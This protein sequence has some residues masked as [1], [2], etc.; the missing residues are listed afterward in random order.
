M[1][2]SLVIANCSTVR[3]AAR[4]LDVGH[5]R[6]VVVDRADAFSHA[7]VRPAGERTLA[8]APL[9]PHVAADALGVV[10]Q[11]QDFVADEQDGNRVDLGR[12]GDVQ[13]ERAYCGVEVGRAVR[14]RVGERLIGDLRGQRDRVGLED[15][16]V[17]REVVQ[18]AHVGGAEDV[19]VD[20]L[21]DL[22]REVVVDIGQVVDGPGVVPVGDRQVV[23]GPQLVQ[24]AGAGLEDE[25]LVDLADLRV[26]RFVR[27]ERL[28]DLQAVG[29]VE[30]AGLLAPGGGVDVGERHVPDGVQP[31]AVGG[32]LTDH[33]VVRGSVSQRVDGD[34]SGIERNVSEAQR[35]AQRAGQ[36]VAGVRPDHF[37]VAHHAVPGDVGGGE[38]GDGLVDAERRPEAEVGGGTGL[39]F[40]AGDSRGIHAGAGRDAGEL[41]LLGRGV[42]GDQTDR[43]GGRARAVELGRVEDGC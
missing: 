26:V 7:A 43:V 32:A 36:Q 34:R 19:G 17:Q 40:G 28:G 15:V 9:N 31:A 8:L 33:V 21:R 30:P 41:G 42:G 4:D 11:Q 20:L 35:P 25:R 24:A 14:E 6:D 38:R 16:L 12:V 27:A 1:Y 37:A 3:C 10:V 2:A 13:L 5:G 39:G 22:D 29:E 23:A 18:P